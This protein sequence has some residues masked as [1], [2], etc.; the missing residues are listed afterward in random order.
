MKTL[1]VKTNNFLINFILCSIF[2]IGKPVTYF[3]LF[4][5]NLYLFDLIFFFLLV[6]NLNPILREKKFLNNNTYLYVLSLIYYFFRIES[7]NFFSLRNG[8]IIL[9]I[10]WFFL[11]YLISLK[12]KIDISVF[13]RSIIWYPFIAF[14]SLI[15]TRQ[16]ITG[17]LQIDLPFNEISLFTQKY[18]YI[19]LKTGLVVVYIC[20]AKKD[21]LIKEG[22]NLYKI[23]IFISGLTLV[24]G[25]TQSRFGF[26]AS[27]IL[28]FIISIKEK[29]IYKLLKIGVASLIFSIFIL[30]II[31]VVTSNYLA[32]SEGKNLIALI[33]ECKYEDYYLFK[34]FKI[35]DSNCEDLNIIYGTE[36]IDLGRLYFR[37]FDY[38]SIV[39]GFLINTQ[40]CDYKFSEEFYKKLDYYGISLSALNEIVAS[41]NLESNSISW[42]WELWSSSIDKLFQNSHTTLFGIG[43][44]KSIPEYSEVNTKIY[45]IHTAHNSYLSV[46]IWAGIVGVIIYIVLVM[47]LINFIK[48][49][50]NGNFVLYVSSAYLLTAFIDQT[51]ETPSNSILFWC[52]I[53]SANIKHNH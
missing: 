14:L 13:Y 51:F 44:D 7:I 36:N 25:V 27:L 6:L 15:L 40:Y 41:S 32:D 23:S 12:D 28:I 18:T 29:L 21:E 49:L 16:D 2:F 9:S 33:E 46:L 35:D 19:L 8:Y 47:K 42:R 4:D 52:I 38:C 53:A 50:N 20:G 17:L 10:S 11:I 24:I 30:P 34:N 1:I 37:K 48:K 45:P 22:I 31:N 3:K 39:N 26:L 43:F 5:L